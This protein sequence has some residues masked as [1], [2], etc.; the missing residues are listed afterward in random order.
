VAFYPEPNGITMVNLS[1]EASMIPNEEF[2]AF[3]K[4]A[5]T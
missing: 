3:V 1:A 4:K 5:I 2:K